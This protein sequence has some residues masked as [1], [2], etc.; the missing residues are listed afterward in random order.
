MYGFCFLK[1]LQIHQENVYFLAPLEITLYHFEGHTVFGFGEKLNKICYTFCNEGTKITK[2]II[3]KLKL[4]F[5]TSQLERMTRCLICLVKMYLTQ[6][7]SMYVLTSCLMYEV[8][9]IIGPHN[10]LQYLHNYHKSF[11][12]IRIRSYNYD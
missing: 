9:W 10:G 3:L 8:L 2:R 7:F 4:K 12:T 11:R 1:L 5:F 6:I